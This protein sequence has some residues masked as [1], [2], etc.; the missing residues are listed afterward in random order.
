MRVNEITAAL[1]RNYIRADEGD[2]QED[3]L[4]LAMES[5]KDYIRHYTGLST[6]ELDDY[7]DLALAYLILIQDMYDQRSMHPDTKY[8][9]SAN[10]TVECILG[11]H[12]RVL[13]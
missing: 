6:A 12:R 1:A 7:E 9:N 13:L 4:Q 5:A 10:K 3:V 2:V 11:M 8:A